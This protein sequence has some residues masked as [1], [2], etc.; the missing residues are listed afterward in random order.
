VT[1]SASSPV[2]SVREPRLYGNWRAERGWGI[3]RL[4]STATIIVFLAVLAPLP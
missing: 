2:T 1:A 4:S 3:G